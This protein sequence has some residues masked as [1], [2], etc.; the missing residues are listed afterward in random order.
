MIDEYFC[1][2]VLLIVSHKGDETSATEIYLNAEYDEP[3]TLEDIARKF[4][5]VSLVIFETALN[6]YVYRY[7]NHKKGKW[8]LVG[9]T[10][11]YA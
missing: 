10:Q 11:G 7:G 2:G 5:D 4:P 9:M 6:G 1:D 3:Y 8:E